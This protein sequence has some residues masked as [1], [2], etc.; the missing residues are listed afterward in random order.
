MNEYTSFPLVVVTCIRDLALLDL[1]AQSMQQYLEPGTTVYIIVNEAD[2]KYW[3]DYFNEH[4]RHY[5]HKHN[6]VVLYKQ[7]FAAVWALR[8]NPISAGWEDQQILKL[9][10]AEKISEPY[11][12]ILDS[13][14]FLVYPFK[15]NDFAMIDG[16]IPYRT[17]RY[18]MQISTWHDYARSVGI[19]LNEPTHNTMAICTPLFMRTS[20]VKNLIAHHKGEVEFSIW[21]HTASRIKSEFILYLFWAEKCGGFNTHHYEKAGWTGSHLRDC[22]NL[23]QAVN[24]FLNHTGKV[25]HQLWS[26]INHR[27]WGDMR[28][29]DFQ[30]VCNK[31]QE[32]NLTPHFDDYRANYV[33]IKI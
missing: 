20:L 9:L 23:H 2:P 25:K 7:E 30:A 28:E 16:K 33:D 18:V 14:N 1:Q 15:K 32:Y 22:P 13:Q 10:I 17:G 4:I 11:Y 12:L 6:L 29:S 8:R 5:Y 19:L 21:F 27:A 31:L 26:M 3:D 24:E